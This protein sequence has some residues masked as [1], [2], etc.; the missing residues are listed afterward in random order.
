[1]VD[2][3][4]KLAEVLLH[5]GYKA[6][7][8]EVAGGGEDDVPWG[9]LL[10]VEVEDGLL[11][12]ARDGLLGPEDGAAQRVALPE[13]LGEELVDEIVGVVLVHLDLFEDDALLALDL[14]GGEGGVKDKVGEDVE[15]R[16]DVLV[17][18]LDVETDVLFAG[19]G[20]EVAADGVDLAGDLTG[21][22]RGCSFEDHV[23]DEM[24]DAVDGDG[25]VARAGVD[26]GSHGD[27]AVMRDAFSE[28]D[29]AVG[30]GGLADAARRAESDA[31]V[32][33]YVDCCHSSI[34]S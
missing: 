26:P 34:L 32:F 8:I 11:I 27:A 12:E 29:K 10:A 13:V 15:G 6:L 1:M 33:D 7:M 17:Q 2:A 3:G 4:G 21:G 5:L 16:G 22:A 24:R 25:L 23:L 14:L 9:E 31:D 19:K 30:E 20:I 18:N 28:N